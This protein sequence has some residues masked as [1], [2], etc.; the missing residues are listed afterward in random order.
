ML[1][2]AAMAYDTPINEEK[3]D[4]DERWFAELGESKEAFAKLYEA[5]STTIYAYAFTFLR[6]R[7]DAEDIMQDTFLKIR[8]AAHLYTPQG[9]PLAWILTITRNLCLMKLRSGKYTSD[10]PLDEDSESLFDAIKDSE[11]RMVLEAAFKVLTEEESRI[12]IL[13][14]VSGL[15]HREIASMLSIPLT[16]VLSKYRRALA[17]LRNAIEA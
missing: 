15:K 16:T 8:S 2:F 3:L 13:H 4:I 6:N 17:K 14:A 9:K 1:I 5:T 7:S 10:M 12:I 11:D